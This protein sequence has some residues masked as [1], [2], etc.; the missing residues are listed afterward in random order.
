MKIH[1]FQA[2]AILGAYEVPVPKG[3]AVTTP[4]DAARVAE[5]LGGAVVLKAQIHAGGRGK[6]GGILSASSPQEAEELAERLI[7]SRLVTHQTGPEGRVVKRILVEE[8]VAVSRELYAGIV[9][10]RRA[11]R[12][13]MM[14]GAIGG[15]EIEEVAAKDP[16]SI[17]RVVVDPAVQLQS[18]HIRRL[19]LR[20]ALPQQVQRTA[21]GLFSALYRVF[22]EKDCSL[23][24]INP[25]VI[26]TDGRLLALDAKL[27]VDDNALFRHADLKAL[28]DPDEELPLEIEASKFGLNYIKLDG[29]VGC[30]VNGAGL[31]MATMDL[32]KFVGGEPAN[33]LD[34]GGGASAEQIEQA[35]RILIS[36]RS[37][38]VVL[39]NIF[40][41]ILRCERL[42]EGV[43][44]A[45]R[46]LGVTMPIV[47]RMEGTNVDHGTRMLTESGL[48]FITAEG[49][50]DAAEKAVKASG[51]GIG[52]RV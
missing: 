38:R 10:D 29:T 25:L 40:G 35:F 1:E 23:V 34:V 31:A 43:I 19:V 4:V 50:Q 5:Q 3:E 17:T 37:V 26:T 45:V 24:E 20:L 39:I 16:E 41:G 27:N 21:T 2:K 7:G 13:V 42:A 52:F 14:A 46:S 15:M 49:M 9:L 6:G 28:R 12:P 48:N 44:R 47:V 30:M 36:D 51:Q 18:F 11:A 33:F 8:Q 22:Q 32:V